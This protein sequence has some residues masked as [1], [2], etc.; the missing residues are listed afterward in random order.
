MRF[1]KK[2]TTCQ[3][4]KWKKRVW[5]WSKILQRGWFWIK[6]FR[7]CLILNQK[8]WKVSFF[9]LKFYKR[10]IIYLKISWFVKLYTLRHS[11][12]VI[13]KFIRFNRFVTFMYGKNF[14][15]NSKSLWSY[16]FNL[17]THQFSTTKS[18]LKW[19]SFWLT[20]DTKLNSMNKSNFS[21][22][23]SPDYGN[24]FDLVVFRRQTI[25]SSEDHC[26]TGLLFLDRRS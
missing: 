21:D 17:W 11:G 12:L 23:L 2:N 26:S 6:R 9:E 1:W 10:Q 3:I 4:L 18:F 7:M 5:F 14:R 16:D 8:F 24:L 19:R 13:R 22:K 20:V 25:G 15:G